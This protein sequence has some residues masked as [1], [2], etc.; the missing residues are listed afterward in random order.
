MKTVNLLFA[1]MIILNI[2]SLKA[3]IVK[4]EVLE[5]KTSDTKQF[6]IKAG[7]A[8]FCC[9]KN[10]KHPN[11]S[12]LEVKNLNKEHAFSLMQ[13]SKKFAKNECLFV[14]EDMYCPQGKDAFT[15]KFFSTLRQT[16]EDSNCTNCMSYIND[17]NENKNLNIE[18]IEF[19][20]P[21]YLY[22]KGH[23]FTNQFLNE[24]DQITNEI[25][26]YNDHPI[27]NDY[28]KDLV[29]TILSDNKEIL[30][31]LLNNKNKNI[32]Q[33]E[34]QFNKEELKSF[35][36]NFNNFVFDYYRLVDAKIIHTILQNKDKK[37]IFIVAG[38][39]HLERIEKVLNELKY[40]QTSLFESD[41]LAQPIKITD[42][43]TQIPIINTEIE[44][45][46]ISIFMALIFILSIKF[47]T[48]FRILH[49]HSLKSSF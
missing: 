43:L 24:I 7:D 32:D 46:Y 14:L 4:L 41:N 34:E 17:L 6:I 38:N 45:P 16:N 48:R 30:E 44:F 2:V 3:F 23:I 9:Q 49:Y 22:A 26:N 11:L 33:I 13:F 20:H 39:N 18:N 35:R 15:D 40:A 21:V 47:P 37:Y 42:T 10:S 12:N 36:D 19:R 29:N 28:Y 25:K 31:I 1:S 27:A 5:N 8:H